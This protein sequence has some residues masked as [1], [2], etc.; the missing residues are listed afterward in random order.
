VTLEQIVA[1]LNVKQIIIC[2]LPNLWD[3]AIKTSKTSRNWERSCINLIF[4]I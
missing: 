4:F 3:L 2:Y 1:C